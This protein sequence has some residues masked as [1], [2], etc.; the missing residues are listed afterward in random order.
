MDWKKTKGF[1]LMELLV[2]IAVIALLLAVLMP[3]LQKAREMAGRMICASNEKQLLVANNL[4]ANAW[5]ECYCPPMMQNRDLPDDD[6]TTPGPPDDMRA[7]NWLTNKT[8]RELMAI[9]DKQTSDKEMILSDDYFCPEDKVARYDKYSTYDVLVSYG[10]N[11]TDWNGQH[12]GAEASLNFGPCF[13]NSSIACTT[14]AVPTWQIGWKRTEI[15]RSAEKINFAEACDW[16]AK[17]S[18]G[19]NYVRGWDI[20]GHG[21]WDD[22]A[23]VGMYGPTLYRHNEGA[24]FAFYDGHV[25]YMPKEKA[26]IDTD[27]DLTNADAEDATEMWYVKYP[28]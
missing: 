21:N 19:A 20:V 24:N 10:Y 25:A 13:W 23:A 12:T 22:Y 28:D 6:P 4:Y 15:R 7:D 2:V 18:D 9:D 11:V 27:D 26:F 8:F 3:S 14:V 5:D 16:W 17:W 1:T